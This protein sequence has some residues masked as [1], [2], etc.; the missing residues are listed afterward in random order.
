ML[1]NIF[2]FIQRIIYTY[3]IKTFK[4][5]LFN[6]LLIFVEQILTQEL[7]TQIMCLVI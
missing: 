4:Y 5:I 6:I 2:I 7:N 3:N 1:V